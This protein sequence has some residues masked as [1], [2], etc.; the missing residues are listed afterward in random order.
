MEAAGID[1]MQI[2]PDHAMDE[3]GDMT[4]LT[5]TKGLRLLQEQRFERVG[6]NETIQTNVR[7]IAGTNRNLKQLVAGGP[8]HDG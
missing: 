4:P 7:V 6:G 2:A 1:G 3:V 5:Q 8:A